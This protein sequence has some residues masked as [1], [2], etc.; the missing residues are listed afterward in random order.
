MNTEKRDR[1]MNTHE[2]IAREREK[3]KRNVA[4]QMKGHRERER[5]SIA[6]R[7]RDRVKWLLREKKLKRTR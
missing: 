4:I 2:R 5:E 3:E 7:K 6:K 1:E